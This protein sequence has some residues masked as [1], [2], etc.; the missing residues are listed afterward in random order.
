MS[1]SPS[2]DADSLKA[3]LLTIPDVELV[4]AARGCLTATRVTRT[5][6]G[7]KDPETGERLPDTVNE[8]DHVTRLRAVEWI[9]AQR[10]LA[11][12][13]PADPPAR[14]VKDA[15][16]DAGTLKPRERAEQVC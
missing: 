9:S 10:G 3:A 15:T 16:G 6:R 1:P 14:K 13:K 12:V 7:Q 4:Q 8:P 5:S 11:G 2:P